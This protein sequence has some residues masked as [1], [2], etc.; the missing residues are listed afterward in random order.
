MARARNIKPGFFKNEDLVELRFEVRLLFA[1]LWTLA[2]REGR[3]E[4]RPKRIKMEIFPAD[5]VDVDR[6]LMELYDTG[7]IVRYEVDQKDYIWIPAF[8]DHQKPH[9]NEAPSKIPP[10][11]TEKHDHG[12]PTDAPRADQS[13]T[14]DSS[15]PASCLNPS[16]LN[17]SSPKK[18]ADKPRKFQADEIEL[19]GEAN[20]DAWRE[21]CEYR[22]ERKKPV[23]EA[24]ARKQLKL[25]CRYPIPVQQQIVDTSIQN[26]YQ[27]L[28]EPKGGT[29]G[30]GTNQ[31][32]TRKLSAVERV[33]ANRR[34]AE[35]AMGDLGPHDGDVRPSLDIIDGR[36]T[37]RY[38]GS[39]SA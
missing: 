23:T 13:T 35:A 4:D 1:G 37:E 24:A 10:Y 29:H 28:F 25:L 7:H 20:P 8:L 17:V 31:P 30:H 15:A 36:R 39:G 12:T 3:L 38:V 26:D 21:W 14:M 18:G 16:C 33:K 22:R 11:Q 27:G 5:D 32:S 2:D 9:R 34:A 19:P 6:A